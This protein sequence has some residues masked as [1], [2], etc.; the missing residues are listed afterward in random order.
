MTP[1]QTTALIGSLLLLVGAGFAATGPDWLGTAQGLLAEVGKRYGPEARG[2][3]DAWLGLIS[4]HRGK[5]EPEQIALVNDFFNR[6]EFVG[7]DEHWGQADYWATPVET[8]ATNGGDCEDFS[9]A[10]YFT[11]R[12]LGVPEERLRL[13]YVKAVKLDQ[14]H[15]VLTYTATPGA[16]PWVLDNLDKAIKPAT[17]RT[18]LQPVYSFNVQ[19]LWLAKERV[20]GSERIG[21]WRGLLA[22]M[23][24]LPGE[25]R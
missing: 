12:S 21:L 7:D 15:M 8:L 10:K 3:V 1:S 11:L 2:R 4:Q 25:P 22:R 17:Q 19:G 5:T 14:A 16:V 24:V 23:G 6:L 18:D 9:I 13:V 20:G